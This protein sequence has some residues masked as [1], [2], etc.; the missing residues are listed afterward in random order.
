MALDQVCEGRVHLCP[1]AYQRPPAVTG[2]R[3]DF[4]RGRPNYH[5]GPRA[6]YRQNE[7]EGWNRHG[8]HEYGPGRGPG[9]PGPGREP[10]PRDGP[11]R[12]ETSDL[13]GSRS[14]YLNDSVH[15]SE[16]NPGTHRVGLQKSEQR[17]AYFHLM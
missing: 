6:G 15:G 8:A 11:R 9:G 1:F 10:N 7:Q 5:D 4:D 16:S 17:V 14:K 12:S 13:D 3:E 2:F